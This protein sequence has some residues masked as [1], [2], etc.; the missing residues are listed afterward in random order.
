MRV[1]TLE[2]QAESGRSE[3]RLDERSRLPGLSR[4]VLLVS[5]VSR[6]EDSVDDS[7]LR[8]EAS[9]AEGERWCSLLPLGAGGAARGVRLAKS[10]GWSTFIVC[11]LP[12]RR[13]S[14]MAVAVGGGLD[15]EA[16]SFWSAI[17][18]CS[19]GMSSR[20]GL[21]RNACL[22]APKLLWRRLWVSRG[23]FV[24]S[25]DWLLP[26]RLRSFETSSLLL[27]VR[28]TPKEARGRSFWTTLLI[29]LEVLSLVCE[30]VIVGEVGV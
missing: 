3:K 21:G 9:E 23:G 11:G 5:T 22:K 4:L 8:N 15:E 20:S 2:S 17:A 25:S 28:R 7:G 30:L 10:E 19:D 27:R 13:P 6:D 14:L 1:E 12:G 18:A 24:E 16:W 29:E 26:V